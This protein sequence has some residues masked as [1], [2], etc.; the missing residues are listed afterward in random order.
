MHAEYQTSIVLND[1]VVQL[2]GEAL[3]AHYACKNL[4]R[5]S[6][7]QHRL[8]LVFLACLCIA[9]SMILIPF[10]REKLFTWAVLFYILLFTTGGVA[11]FIAGSY[12]T[13][14]VEQST[15]ARQEAQE[16]LY[17][18]RDDEITIT[19][20][21]GRTTLS[22]AGVKEVICG[23]NYWLL[24]SQSNESNF[25]VLDA[26]QLSSELKHYIASK[27]SIADNEFL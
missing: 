17:V 18:F 11:G 23:D 24:T 25:L 15:R 16:V 13:A 4:D 12:F 7:L 5:S 1:D 14:E 10:I 20:K 2:A 26:A 6:R 27:V 19:G 3:A 22:W 8:F 21:Y 9:L